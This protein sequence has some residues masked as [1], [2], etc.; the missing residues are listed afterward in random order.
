M[1]K[2]T[3]DEEREQ[4]WP[5]AFRHGWRGSMLGGNFKWRWRNAVH[6]RLGHFLFFG[7]SSS[8]LS[9]LLATKPRTDGIL[10]E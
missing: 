7:Q 1:K 10:A 5:F 6:S 3:Q 2:I 8:S 9:L 4:P